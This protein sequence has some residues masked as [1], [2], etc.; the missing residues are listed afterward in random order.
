MSNSSYTLLKN[1]T[2]KL[3]VNISVKE[4]MGGTSSNEALKKKYT[5]IA[6]AVGLYWYIENNHLEYSF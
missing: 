4:P 3:D 1:S 5:Q 6:I 2:D